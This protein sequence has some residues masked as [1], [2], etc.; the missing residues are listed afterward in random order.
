MNKLTIKIPGETD[1]LSSIRN[2]VNSYCLK[3]GISADV[4]G[5]IEFA[6]DEGVT[7][8][9]KHAYDEDP[10]L[11][12]ENRVIELEIE[13]QNDE[14]VVILKDHA[15]P[16]NPVNASLPDLNAHVASR[17][18]HGLGVF[19]M[20]KFMDRMEHRYISGFGNEVRL[21]KKIV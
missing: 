3:L 6:V 4:I 8:I 9:I 18:T 2:F 21:Y 10:D 13:Q 1:Y 15:G 5:D 7:N 17:K 11:P 16:Y 14:I 19:A 20:K 12:D